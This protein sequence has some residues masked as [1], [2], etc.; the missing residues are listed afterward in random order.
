MKFLNVKF[1][2]K[3]ILNKKNI[4][5]GAIILVFTIGIIF[6]QN[7][8]DDNSYAMENNEDVIEYENKEG[9]FDADG[10]I[11]NKE[12][13]GS[14]QE[15]GE[16]IESE[17]NAE[18]SESEEN[19]ES[20]GNEKDS[21]SEEGQN[22]ESSNNEAEGEDVNFAEETESEETKVIFKQENFQ[23]IYV[24]ITGEVNNPGVVVLKEGSRIVDAIEA[25]GGV[26]GNANISKVNLVYVLL[27]GMK[28]NIPSDNDLKKNSNYEYI[29]MSSGDDKSD[30]NISSDVTTNKG[31]TIDSDDKNVSAFKQSIVNINTATQTELETLPGIG[32]SI[33]LNIINYRKENGKFANIEDIK[34]V[35]GI[36]D[37]KFE[38]IKK[39]IVI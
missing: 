12:K 38:N 15:G 23:K 3:K 1:M 24:Y 13:V 2:S 35:S 16:D 21:D 6:A 20:S 36:G 7:F 14:K 25:A 29:T 18:T 8:I 10:D 32:P 37:S 33:A 9:D 31:N 28:V 11:N 27:D 30:E 34:N 22:G 5:I 19:I 17:E 4:A 39:Y 26:T